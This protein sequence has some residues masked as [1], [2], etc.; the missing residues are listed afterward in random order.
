MIARKWLVTQLAQGRNEVFGI[1]DQRDGIRDQKGGIKDHRPWDRDQQFFLR[2][3]DQAALYLWDQRRNLVTLLESRIR[4]LRTEMGSA[5]KKTYLV[6]T[7]YFIMT[8][9]LNA[10]NG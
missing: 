2:I 3:R 1:K 9:P 8:S 10:N 5:M 7:L 6:T 4:N